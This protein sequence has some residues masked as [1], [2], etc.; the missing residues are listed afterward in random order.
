MC[1]LCCSHITSTHI[2]C[3]II[4]DCRKLKHIMLGSHQMSIMFIPSFVKINYLVQNLKGIFT[5][6]Q[7]ND[8]INLVSFFKKRKQ[9]NKR[10]IL[11][12][13]TFSQWFKIHRKFMLWQEDSSGVWYAIK[14]SQLSFLD[15]NSSTFTLHCSA[16][17]WGKL[18]EIIQHKQSS[19]KAHA[20]WHCQFRINNCAN[21][22]AVRKPHGKRS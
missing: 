22:T 18:F 15:K 7:S 20:N 21:K 6:G 1:C 4:V 10:E 16:V 9:V 17:V 3:A 14:F 11:K 5:H 12:Y 19:C 8:L 2:C 13:I